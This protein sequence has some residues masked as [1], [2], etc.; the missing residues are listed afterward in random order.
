MAWLAGQSPS[1]PRRKTTNL[2][3]R[4]ED[5]HTISVIGGAATFR[6]M[7]GLDSDDGEP[8]LQSHWLLSADDV[9][10][11]SL[12]TGHGPQGLAA[13]DTAKA[14]VAAAL[15]GKLSGSSTQVDVDAAL[16]AALAAADAAVCGQCDGGSGAAALVCVLQKGGALTVANVGDS[17]VVLG[18]S[19]NKMC[20]GLACRPLTSA[21][22]V[23]SQ[24]ELERCRAHGMEAD[25]A[26]VYPAGDEEKEDHFPVTRILGASRVK[27]ACAGALLATPETTHHQLDAAQALILFIATSALLCAFPAPKLV[28]RLSRVLEGSNND[29]T[30]KDQVERLASGLVDAIKSRDVLA[31]AVTL[32]EDSS[33]ILALLPY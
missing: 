5:Q 29:A 33:F 15:T 7:R 24:A 32:E 17:Q 20:S 14:A 22:S 3:N 8:L 21:H 26:G 4:G 16:A 27:A 1:Q 6:A 10:I 19:D 23:R 25:E 9:H 11:F 31:D 13:V 18:T 2:A 12:F 30:A 28:L